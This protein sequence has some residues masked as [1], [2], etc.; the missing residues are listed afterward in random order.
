MQLIRPVRAKLAHAAN[1]RDPL[2]ARPIADLPPIMHRVPH[3]NYYA[4]TLVP[5]YALGRF[6]HRE[7]KTGPFI[8]DEGFVAGAE[9]TPVDL[10][11]D[12]VRLGVRDVDFRHWGSGGVA[13]ALTHSGVLLRGDVY[14]GHGGDYCSQQGLIAP[15]V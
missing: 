3:G 15:W 14:G 8:V 13:G 7:A 9:A 5:G 1:A 4:G 10:D 11:E 12:L 6:L 2:D